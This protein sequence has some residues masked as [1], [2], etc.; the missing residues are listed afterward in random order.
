MKR[1]IIAGMAAAAA[2]AL[3]GCGADNGGAGLPAASGGGQQTALNPRPEE[4][5]TS[6]AGQLQK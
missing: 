2:L 4:V 1:T 6:A 3:S 5:V